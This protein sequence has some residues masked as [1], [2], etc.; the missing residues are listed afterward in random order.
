MV[1][2]RSYLKSVN[3]MCSMKQ[4]SSAVADEYYQSFEAERRHRPRFWDVDYCLLNQLSRSVKEFAHTYGEHDDLTIVDYGC[5]AKPYRNFFR[6][7]FSYIGIDTCPNP[8]ADIIVDNNNTIPLEDNIADLL[9]STQV[10]Y[11]IPEYNFY[12]SE[13]LRLLKPAG[14]M[15]ISVCSTWTYHPASGGDYYRFTK[16]GLRYILEKNGFEIISL[17]SI[18]GTLGTGLHLRQLVFNAWLKRVR[19]YWVIPLYNTITNIRI[20]LEERLT[21]E[22]TRFAS[23]VSLV[24]IAKPK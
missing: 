10:V 7:E 20:M 17:K 2:S 1:I 19:Q 14:T 12:L 21:T 11:L 23:P 6:K 13:A 15:F 18:V 5:G 9:I 8:Y 22:N 24:A 4:E 16:D 3:K